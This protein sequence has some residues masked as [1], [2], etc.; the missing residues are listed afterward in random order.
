MNNKNTIVIY[1]SCHVMTMQKYVYYFP[2]RM[3]NAKG[4][5]G[6]IN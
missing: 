1:S 5:R 2:Q 6:F 3:Y 4:V